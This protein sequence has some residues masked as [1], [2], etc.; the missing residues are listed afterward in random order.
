MRLLTLSFL[1][2]ATTINAQQGY[3]ITYSLDYIPDTTSEKKINK[4]E[5]LDIKLKS[6]DL[7]VERAKQHGLTL[8][9]EGKKL[10]LQRQ[11]EF[12]N[13]IEKNE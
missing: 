11:S 10:L 5:Y 6:Q 8:S 9:E 13:P 12:N 3:L 2:L 7:I 4:K 1:L